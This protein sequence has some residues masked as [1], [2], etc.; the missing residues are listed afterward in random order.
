MGLVPAAMR[1]RIPRVHPNAATTLARRPRAR[2]AAI[3]K[4]A[5]VPG[6]ATMIRVLTSAIAISGFDRR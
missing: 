1:G 5:P 2:P 4:S 3:A 6:E